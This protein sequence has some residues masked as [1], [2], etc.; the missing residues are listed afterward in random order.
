M[1]QSDM[2]L[3]IWA[4]LIRRTDPFPLLTRVPNDS[5]SSPVKLTRYRFAG[6]L[7]PLHSVS[8]ESLPFFS[9][10]GKP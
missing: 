4:R 2:W 8:E 3:G 10:S 7:S 6:I 1:M 9:L 5:R